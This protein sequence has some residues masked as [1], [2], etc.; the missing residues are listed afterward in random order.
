VVV[1]AI[2]GLLSCAPDVEEPVM[3]ETEDIAP[4]IDAEL[5]TEGDQRAIQRAVEIS[6]MVPG[7][8][9]SD[10]PLFVPSSVVDFG[11]VAGGRRYVELVTTATPRE[12]RGWL[13]G[14]LPAAG[15][16]VG[17]VGDGLV[18]AHKGAQQVEYRLTDLAPGTRIRLEYGP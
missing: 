13:G 5:S 11:D 16:T 4:P 6:G 18:Q 14:R 3:I 7:D 17:A 10:L 1:L 12:V 9:P 2:A 8:V 15:W